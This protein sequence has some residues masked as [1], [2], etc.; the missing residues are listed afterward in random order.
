MAILLADVVFDES[1][2]DA[3]IGPVRV[4][5]AF[6]I[7]KGVSWEACTAIIREVAVGALRGTPVE[8][9]DVIEVGADDVVEFISV[10]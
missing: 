5:E 1:A 6:A 8:N 3:V 2:L 4:C 7:L 10:N 9:L